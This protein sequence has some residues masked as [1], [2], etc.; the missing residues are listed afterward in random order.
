MS[1]F[2]QSLQAA[3]TTGSKNSIGVTALQMTTTSKKTNGGVVV[4]ASVVN[5]GRVYVGTNSSITANTNPSTDGFELAAGES[6]LL[7]VDN[8][9]S[10]YL[11]GSTTGQKVFWMTI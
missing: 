5:S 2:P 4:K 7:P 1:K 10:I 6:V 9:N 3:V 8:Q 11:I